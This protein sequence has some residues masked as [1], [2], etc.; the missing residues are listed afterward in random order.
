MLA[1][2]DSFSTSFI[3]NSERGRSPSIHNCSMESF[4]NTTG[5]NSLGKAIFELFP[6]RYRGIIATKSVGGKPRW[7]ERKYLNDSDIARY[8][9][10]DFF[11]GCQLR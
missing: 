11:L 2:N 10:K 7:F 5:L 1:P 9:E 6:C 3:T 8:G 4:G